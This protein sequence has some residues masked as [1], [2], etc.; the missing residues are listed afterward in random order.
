[1]NAGNAFYKIAELH[2]KSENYPYS[3][4]WTASSV[5][6]TFLQKEEEKKRHLKKKIFIL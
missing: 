5:M 2:E 4:N 3:S 6:M 1:M